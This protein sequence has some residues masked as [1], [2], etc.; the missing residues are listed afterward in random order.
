MEFEGRIVDAV[1]R[2]GGICG[3]Y[4]TGS[5]AIGE[6]DENSN[7]DLV[8]ITKKAP[9]TVAQCLVGELSD[10]PI[11]FTCIEPR[12]RD[13]AIVSVFISEDTRYLHVEIRVH[14]EEGLKKDEELRQRR[15]AGQWK[16]LVSPEE[17]NEIEVQAEAE[18]R[19]RDEKIVVAEEETAKL[20]HRLWREY[21]KALSEY[22]RGRALTVR[23]ALLRGNEALKQILEK[24]GGQQSLSELESISQKLST[25]TSPEEMLLLGKG[26]IE[27]AKPALSK[28]GEEGAIPVELLD[29]LTAGWEDA[30]AE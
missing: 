13:S 3:L 14:T 29:R 23:T 25:A 21:P 2:V 17:L 26:A 27:A 19:L 24:K 4:L 15:A 5:R 18:R 22:K 9:M 1:R 8:L 10:L 7:W 28:A 30:I 12:D 6:A 11:L 16:V 20:F